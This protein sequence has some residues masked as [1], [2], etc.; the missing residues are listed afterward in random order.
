MKCAV[1]KS[2]VSKLTTINTNTYIPRVLTKKT[3]A[4]IYVCFLVCLDFCPPLPS[5][6]CPQ[7]TQISR[8]SGTLKEFSKSLISALSCGYAA[9][10]FLIVLTST[11]PYHPQ[12]TSSTTTGT[13]F[14]VPVGCCRR[15]KTKY[16]EF[17]SLPLINVCT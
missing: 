1:I 12:L 14:L 15:H 8:T 4:T 9:K 2:G 10:K 6:V 17:H 7:P 11:L 5:V 3:T 13:N 16:F